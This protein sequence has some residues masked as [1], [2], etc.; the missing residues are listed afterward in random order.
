MSDIKT[1]SES[2]EKLIT[3]LVDYLENNGIRRENYLSLDDLNDIIKSVH[4]MTSPLGA[5]SQEIKQLHSDM[6]YIGRGLQGLMKSGEF[7]D[8]YDE[9][10]GYFNAL[11]VAHNSI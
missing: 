7:D 6:E 11:Q 8:K 2:I 5:S 4:L 9:L 3:E 1:V 10:Q